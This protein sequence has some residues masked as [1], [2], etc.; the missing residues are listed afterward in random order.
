MQ[1]FDAEERQ[2]K[3]RLWSVLCEHFFQRYI[4]P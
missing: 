3:D 2:R 4:G 1:R